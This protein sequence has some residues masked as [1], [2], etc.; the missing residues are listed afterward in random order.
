MPTAATNITDTSQH[1]CKYHCTAQC[2][3]RRRRQVAKCLQQQLILLTQVNTGANI[4]A[5]HSAR[6][7]VVVRLLNAYSSNKYY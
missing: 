1:Q 4:I 3:V 7:V 6:R 2:T 5:L